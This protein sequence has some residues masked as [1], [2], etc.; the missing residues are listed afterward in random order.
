MNESQSTIGVLVSGGL[1]SAILVSYLLDRGER[2]RPIY[3]TGDLYWQETELACLKGYL[4]A[5]A[6]PELASLIV[7]EVP[8]AD[9]YADHWSTSGR[10]V[11][12]AATPD[13]AVYLPGRNLL[14]SVKPALWCQMHGIGRLAIGVLSSNP[15]DD[16]SDRFFAALEAVLANLG[17]PPITIERPFGVMS[18][19]Q[20]ME[21]GRKYPLELSFSCIAPIRGLHCGKCNK[22]AERR[23][24][25]HAAELVDLT[26]YA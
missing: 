21:L 4:Q 26:T 7:L 14:L 2:V 18:K 11:P 8:M 24:A 19:Q 9:L 3:V 5:I 6:R 16:T 12:D 25:F 23:A 20:V 1:D 10:N 13:E 15:F 22:C 17:Q